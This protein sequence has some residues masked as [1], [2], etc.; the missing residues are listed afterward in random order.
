M[1][2]SIIINFEVIFKKT[3]NIYI[4]F[5]ILLL[6]QIIVN[7][8]FEKEQKLMKKIKKYICLIKYI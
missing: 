2:R 1:N 3:K 4:I 7:S 5:T 8:L 6:F